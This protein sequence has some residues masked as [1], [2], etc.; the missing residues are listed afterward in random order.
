M[1]RLCLAIL[2][3][4][5]LA[6]AGAAAADPVEGSWRTQAD[7]RGNFA[8]V[9]ISSCGDRICG[10][11]ARAF[12]AEGREIRSPT[13][14]RPIIWDMRP[15]GGGEYVDGKIWAP[16]RDKTYNSKMTLSGDRLSVR[17]C[18]LGLCRGQVWARAR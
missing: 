4:A 8:I 2:A 18:V 14:G 11:I 3:A 17:G 10:T 9:A 16:D 1:R 5:G 13:V 7:D 15:A 6:G 12:D